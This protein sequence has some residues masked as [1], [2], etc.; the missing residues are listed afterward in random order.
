MQ[1]QSNDRE[2][3]QLVWGVSL[4]LDMS[5]FTALR[6][7]ISAEH[8]L[9]PEFSEALGRIGLSGSPRSISN[10]ALQT[11]IASFYEAIHAEE[12]DHCVLLQQQWNRTGEVFLK[13][14]N[15][16]FNHSYNGPMRFFA[17]PSIWRVHI[18]QP[19]RHAISFPLERD[20]R[21]KDEAL[22]VV[23]HELLHAFFFDFAEATGLLKDRNDVWDISEIFNVLVLQQARFADLYPAHSIIPYP[24]HEDIVSGLQEM[25]PGLR[26]AESIIKAI[27]RYI[28]NGRRESLV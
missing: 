6:D 10:E 13:R 19:D 27:C 24:Q 5:G 26:N 11:H 21:D 14:S 12:S 2:G 3:V 18:Q 4:D 22:Y 28:D 15:E 16:L 9:F 25:L 20:T 23:V 17:Y 1:G 7:E 8:P